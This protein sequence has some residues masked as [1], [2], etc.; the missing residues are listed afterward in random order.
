MRMNSI[1]FSLLTVQSSYSIVVSLFSPWFL[2][3]WKANFGKIVIAPVRRKIFFRCVEQ[4]WYEYRKLLYMII[5][6]SSEWS[7]QI[8]FCSLGLLIGR[9]FSSGYL[10]EWCISNV[11]TADSFKYGSAALPVSWNNWI[12]SS[13]SSPPPLSHSRWSDHLSKISCCTLTE[14]CTQQ[15]CW[16]GPADFPG[17]GNQKANV[18]C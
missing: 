15:R 18:G 4:L 14:Q 6:N 8:T 9:F 2:P 5:D 10:D 17:G 3:T 1:V 16:T 7:D 11:W 13:S 12:P